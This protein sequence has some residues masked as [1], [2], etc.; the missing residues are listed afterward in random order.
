MADELT[1]LQRRNMAALRIKRA[2][3]RNQFGNK[4]QIVD[5]DEQVLART[6]PMAIPA[7]A[8]MTDKQ[9]VIRMDNVLELPDGSTSFVSD[10]KHQKLADNLED[11]TDALEY[12]ADLMEQQTKRTRPRQTAPEFV[13]PA[14][15]KLVKIEEEAPVVAEQRPV[16]LPRMNDIGIAVPRESSKMSDK[17]ALDALLA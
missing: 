17:E 1:D 16:E 3:I 14:G 9:I 13:V 12:T 6:A 8:I 5:T 15:Y 10:R 11:V 4:I 2:Q 7:S